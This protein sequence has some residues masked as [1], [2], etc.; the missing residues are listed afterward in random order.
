M[1]YQNTK[2]IAIILRKI[3]EYGR[4]QP[5]NTSSVCVQARNQAKYKKSKW[6]ETNRWGNVK[7]A[8]L[9][10]T[11][12]EN[13][14]IHFSILCKFLVGSRFL[15]SC[16]MLLIHCFWGDPS[17]WVT[18]FDFIY[19]NLLSCVMWMEILKW[20]NQ[21]FNNGWRFLT[22]VKKEW[23]IFLYLLWTISWTFINFVYWEVFVSVLFC[24]RYSVLSNLQWL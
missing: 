3:K 17:N 18:G 19:L 16:S 8:F 22:P 5:K 10:T 6:G 13:D 2:I 24:R 1:W 15:V 14:G 21:L 20:H 23:I 12:G 4:V 11:L 9:M 7:P